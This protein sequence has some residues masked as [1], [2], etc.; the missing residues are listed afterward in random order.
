MSIRSQF[1]G[2][3]AALVLTLTVS[4]VWAQDN[5]A[6]LWA[7][8]NH[9]VLVARP[10]LA[11]AAG[12]ALLDNVEPQA[13]LDAVE[14]SDYANYD[15]ALIRAQRTEGLGDVAAKLDAKI[16]Q[17][18]IERSRET[19]RIG[20][21]ITTLSQGQRPYRNAVERLKAAGQ[22][23][24]PQMLA[25]LRDDGQAEL[26]PYVLQAMVAVGRP[27][28]A[29]LSEALPKLNAVNQARVAQVLAEI[30]YPHPLPYLKQVLES[31]TADPNAR[32]TVQRAYDQ[33]IERTELSGS[34]DA[35]TLYLLLGESQYTR[36]T[37]GQEIPG[38]DASQDKGIVWAYAED[39][40]LVPIPVPGAVFG[41][42]LAMRAA[43][44]A[45]TLDPDLDRALSLYLM[46]NLRRENNLPDGEQ[47]PSY[48]SDKQAPTF[49]ALLAG[50]ARLQDVLARAL[51]DRDSA[52]AIDAIDALRQTAGIKD[53]TA[54]DSPLLTALSY[55]D[56]RVRFRAA[57][58]LTSARPDESFPGSVRVV[59]VLAEALR[60]T[61]TQVA[62]V[63]ADN[64][65]LLNNLVA[66]ATE[67]NYTVVSGTSLNG[68]Q[69]QVARA[70]TV[71][72]I[73]VGGSASNVE[74]VVKSSA[75]DYR[76][77]AVPVLAVVS[78][79]TQ[80][81]LHERHGD[82]ARLVTTLIPAEAEG[83]ADAL[84]A[85]LT[86]VAPQTLGDEEAQAQAFEALSLLAT[87]ALASDVYR[88]EDALPALA[89]S[90]QRG[91]AQVVTGAGIVLSLIDHAEAQKALAEASLGNEGDTQIALLEALADSGTHFG[92]QLDSGATDRLL[93]LVLNSTGDTALAAAKAHGALALPTSNSVQ[94]ILK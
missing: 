41:D 5:A 43:E 21:D 14:A 2:V 39:T 61:D 13:L 33:L 74:G 72:V 19:E 94:E 56:R 9:Y 62:L 66:G 6:S 52:L 65:D 75:G 79:A 57:A 63:L 22:Y 23:A 24:A 67:L 49:Y 3:M 55:P 92:N 46:A 60:P 50:P 70:A 18:R 48:G 32:Q 37:Q 69:D 90:V 17:A 58:A 51:A 35:A 38:Y 40:G 45:L 30:G 44:Q 86:L 73:I 71:D 28:V 1:G 7:D 85:A 76:L 16:Q 20:T 27:L 84:D 31:E 8:F 34:L 26:H 89:A 87:V 81:E 59:P 53:Q 82:N 11:S 78:S 80:I 93:D 42:V 36:Q 47:D 4:P 68:V 12:Q 88:I 54:G 29:P 15:R 10:D 83:M 25:V 91:D 77:G 64:Q